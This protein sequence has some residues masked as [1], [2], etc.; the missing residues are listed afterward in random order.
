MDLVDTTTNNDL[1]INTLFTAIA[2]AVANDNPTKTLRLPPFIPSDIKNWLQS[3]IIQLS[4]TTFFTP[5]LNADQSFVSVI[6]AN[7]NPTVDTALY[8]QLSKTI[9]TITMNILNPESTS[10]SGVA[11]LVLLQAKISMSKS[12]NDIDILYRN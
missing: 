2:S 3:I 1:D 6:N 9:P 10:K 8:T 12:P 5:Q 7:E 4:Y 11:I